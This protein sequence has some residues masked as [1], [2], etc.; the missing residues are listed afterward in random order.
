MLKER[1]ITAAFMLVMVM[2]VL[3]VFPR[4]LFSLSLGF[5]ATAAAWEW[6][7]LSGLV[8]SRGQ[9]SY[10]TG[11]G[12]LAS[13]ATS[14]PISATTTGFVCVAAAVFW[15]VIMQRLRTHAVLDT[16]DAANTGLLCLGAGLLGA[17]VM[18]MM[19][20]RFDAEFASPLLLLYAL[21]LVWL[22]DIGAYFSG[23]RFGRRK[24]AVA[25]SPGKT[26]EGVWGG[27]AVTALTVV[28]VVSL[29][30]MPDGVGWRLVVASI[31]AA[32]LSVVGDLYESRIKR[33]AGFKDS[34]QLLP[35]HGGLLDRVDGVLAAVPVFVAVWWLLW[36]V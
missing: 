32:A 23:R 9:L 13:V 16:I 27:L 5:L 25:I 15:I 19:A 29:A 14:L 26:W 36:S 22:M 20:L 21:S 8:T 11:V 34:S 1:V 33:A 24:L 2:L 18:A 4:S 17:T 12:L 6:G 31:P 3:F 30:A 7:R 10:A 28:L 35:G